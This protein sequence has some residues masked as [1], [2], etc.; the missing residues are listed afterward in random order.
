MHSLFERSSEFGCGGRSFVVSTRIAAAGE[1]VVDPP[2]C[3][4]F[5]GRIGFSMATRKGEK[6]LLQ[7]L[8]ARQDRVKVLSDGKVVIESDSDWE[9]WTP[10]CA[11]ASEEDG[12]AEAK[13]QKVAKHCDAQQN[14]PAEYGKLTKN[15]L[16][17]WCEDLGLIKSKCKATM[18][19]R[20]K[21]AELL[22]ELKYKLTTHLVQEDA[23]L[24]SAPTSPFKMPPPPPIPATPPPPPPL[25]EGAPEPP[26]PPPPPPLPQQMRADRSASTRPHCRFECKWDGCWNYN[27]EHRKM[28]KHYNQGFWA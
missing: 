5:V 3:E 28:F 2:T 12:E 24:S 17:E 6:T 19:A 10:N 26:L 20:I 15:D 23:A 18:W 16:R 13:R 25:P 11:T 9:S 14:D 21:Q 7:Y 27:A 8:A 4:G 22:D 1:S